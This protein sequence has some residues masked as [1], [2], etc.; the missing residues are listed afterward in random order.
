M[1]SRSLTD[2]FSVSLTLRDGFPLLWK[3]PHFRCPSAPSER[4]IND[5]AKER[6]A[7]PIILLLAALLF[8]LLLFILARKK[9]ILSSLLI[10]SLQP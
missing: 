5:A 9:F 7:E 8:L 10:L 6:T 4:E 3:L 2:V 1:L